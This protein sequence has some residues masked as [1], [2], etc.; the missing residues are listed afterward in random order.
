MRLCTAPPTVFDGGTGYETG[1]L[2]TL[3]GGVLSGDGSGIAAT[4]KVN[5]VEPG[6]AVTA[7][8]FFQ[9]G[10]YAEIPPDRAATTTD[11]EQGSGAILDVT[12]N[13]PRIAY[14]VN[15][16]WGSIH[17]W[18]GALH[19]V[20]NDAYVR[21]VRSVVPADAGAGGAGAG[22]VSGNGDVNGDNDV[23]I[24]DAV[25]LLTF[26]FQGGDPPK[27]CSRETTC[28]DGEDGDGA[29]D[30]DDP[31]CFVDANC[32]DSSLLPDTS[33]TLCQ[34]EN[35]EVIDCASV[36]ACAGQDSLTD[37]GC[38]FATRLVVNEDGTVSD[39]CTGLMWLPSFRDSVGAPDWCAAMDICENFL[40]GQAGFDD[41]RLPNIRELQSIMDYGRAHPA[42]DI[43]LW[44]GEPSGFENTCIWSS[45]SLDANP[46][47]AFIMSFL[48]GTVAWRGKTGTSRIPG[49]WTPIAVRTP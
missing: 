13:P 44:Y 32:L 47:S 20:R 46:S 26:L 42:M 37:N 22:T 40:A 19:N 1:D 49:N 38:D 6:G 30:C 48:H 39:T 36:G 24:A 18:D 8:G 33:Q 41:W 25:Y 34:D 27:S 35:G 31:D 3:V 4:F 12:Y 5:T 21:A 7:V 10:K 16:E 14:F 43:Q 45:T 15:Y 11:S 9:P 23:D 29:T 28:D 17:V 2:L